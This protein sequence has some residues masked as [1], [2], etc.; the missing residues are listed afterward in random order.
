M[1]VVQVKVKRGQRKQSTF[2]FDLHV[3]LSHI[4]ISMP[5]NDPNMGVVLHID[6]ISF[7]YLLEL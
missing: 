1:L 6:Q 4:S 7:R 5:Y 3:A 2:G